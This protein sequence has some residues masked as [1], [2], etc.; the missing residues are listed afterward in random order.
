MIRAHLAAELAERVTLDEAARVLPG[1]GST[2]RELMAEV[3]LRHPPA[4]KLLASDVLVDLAEDELAVV[5]EAARHL[6]TGDLPRLLGEPST[7][8]NLVESDWDDVR[9]FAS[10]L[11][12]SLDPERLGLDELIA[13]CDS[14][15]PTQGLG[16]ELVLHSLPRLALDELILRLAEHPDDAVRGFAA[17]L[18]I[19]RAP[20]GSVPL[21]RLHGFLRTVFYRVAHGRRTKRRLAAHLQARARVSE[22]EARVVVSVVGGLVH[23]RCQQDRTLALQLVAEVATRHP[24]VAV[25]LVAEGPPCS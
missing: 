13:L 1:A 24:E 14:N 5:R 9:S 15:R 4:P 22:R 12:R 23:A 7:L 3:V 19:E 10:D 11:L 16:R 8:L 25:P 6:L 21:L 18:L 2:L 20:P 17:E